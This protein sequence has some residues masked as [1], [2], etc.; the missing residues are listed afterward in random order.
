MRTINKSVGRMTGLDMLTASQR[1]EAAEHDRAVRDYTPETVE[2]AYFD[3]DARRAWD[4][5][6]H[7][8]RWIMARK[9]ALLRLGH[10]MRE[11]GV[12]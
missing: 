3:L 10:S 9:A 12:A 8:H 6:D 5:K 2:A 4:K 1:R 7:E 11:R